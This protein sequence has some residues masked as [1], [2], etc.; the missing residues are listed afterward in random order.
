MQT[1]IQGRSRTF[2]A[3]LTLLT[4]LGSAQATIFKDKELDALSDANKF[5][6]LERLAQ[7]RLK[8]NPAD[9]EASAALSLALSSLDPSDSKR[10]EAGAKQAKVCVEQH[11]TVAVCQLVTAQ[12][13]NVQMGSAGMFKMASMLGDIKAA[14]IR[15][16][17]LEPTQAMARIQLAKLYLFA[18]GMLGGSVAKARELEAAV[19]NSQPEQARIIRIYIAAEGKKWAE[20]EAELLALKPAKD[21]TLLDESRNAYLQL[22]THYLKDDKDFAKAKSLFEQLQRE[23]PAQAAGVYGL[24]R[25]QAEMGQADEAVRLFERARTLEGADDLPI[26][27]RLGDALLAKGDKPQAKAAYERFLTKKNANPNNVE[28]ARKSLAKL[29]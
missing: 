8:A 7:T 20:M 12:S 27:H 15:T 17:E 11:P 10:V 28:A 1:R 23:Q 24:G 3:A 22:A 5:A 16:L 13:L 18:P 2:L 21:A 14:L 6:E 4:A 26:D 9:A 29:S 19:R 25:V